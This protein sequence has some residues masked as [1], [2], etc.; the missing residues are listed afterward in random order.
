MKK[1]YINQNGLCY[2]CQSDNNGR[3]LAVDHDHITGNI[4]HLL[5][6]NCNLGLGNFKDNQELLIKAVLYLKEFEIHDES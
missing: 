6:I 4:R 5:C 1:M 2:I 3:L